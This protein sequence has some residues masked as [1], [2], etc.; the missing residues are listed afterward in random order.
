MVFIVFI[1]RNIALNVE[2]QVKCTCYVNLM[3]LKQQKMSLTSCTTGS[4]SS[5]AMLD[6]MHSSDNLSLN[7]STSKIVISYF[8]SLMVFI[9]E[10]LIY[11]TKFND[12]INEI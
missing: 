4:S 7:K 5:S 2:K 6:G 1:T 10:D 12:M 8:F 9:K 3:H 11:K